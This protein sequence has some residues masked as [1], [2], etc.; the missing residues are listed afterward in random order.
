M[1]RFKNIAC[2]ILVLSV[3]L[4]Y[5]PISSS[6][7]VKPVT[8]RA[9][10]IPFSKGLNLKETF[11]SG[12]ALALEFE[13]VLSPGTVTAEVGGEILFYEDTKTLQVRGTNGHLSSDG[14]I[15]LTGDMVMDF[16]VPLPEAFFEE[17]DNPHIQH[18]GSIP[19]FPR[20]EKGWNESKEFDSF[21][22]SDS[23]PESVKLNVG[24]PQLVSMRL[25]AVEIVPVVT[26]AI[27][28]GGTLTAAVKIFVDHLSDYLDAGIS[29]N[30][31]IASEL[32]L[33][34]KAITINDAPVTHENRLVR[35]PNFDSTEGTYQIESDYDEEF[36]YT[37]D[38]VASSNAYAKVVV[39][40]GIEIWSYDE[41]FAEKR[42]SVIPKST[43]NL[44]F[45]GAA[46]S[47]T[48]DVPVE[49][50]DQWAGPGVI[51][52]PGLASAIRRT[53][54]I[55]QN[56]PITRN[57]MRKLTKL[58]AG[59]ESIRDLTGLKYAVNL[60]ELE[61]PSNAISDVS[62][63]SELKKLENL[64]ISENRL[65]K[66]SLSD[67][68]NLTQLDLYSNPLSEVSLSGM[69]NLT[70][71][72]FSGYVLSEVSLSNMPKLEFLGFRGSTI[73]ELSLSGLTNLTK[74]S[75]SL[76]LSGSTILKLS[77]SGLTNLTELGLASRS[78]SEVSLSDL[79]NLEDLYLS[80]NALSEVSL[81]S[82]PNLINLYLSG[83]ALSEVSL[84][85]MPNLMNLYLE[86]NALSEV[87]L[88][89]MPNLTRLLL[90]DNNLLKIS[91]PDMPNLMYLVLRNNALSEI[92]LPNMPNL[93]FLS[94]GNNTLSEISL[95]DMP[96]LMNLSLGNNALSEI[97]LP[98][99]PNLTNLS[100]PHNTL[101]EISLPSMPNLEVLWLFNNA[102]SEISLSDMPN[103]T[104]LNIQRNPLSK[105]SLSNMPKLEYFSASANPTLEVSL[106]NLPNLQYLDLSG[107]SISEVFLMDLTNLKTLSLSGNNISDVSGLSGLPNLMTLYLDQNNISDV[108]PLIELPNLTDLSLVRNPLNYVS[109]RTHIPA[110][111]ARGV[112][113]QFDKRVSPIFVKIS[114]EDQIGAPGLALPTPFI[115]QVLDVEDKPIPNIPIRFAV[116]QG[117]GT[118]STTN[119]TT[120]ATG[121]A[122]TVLTL[123]P[124]P[125]EN[126]VGVI[127]EGFEEAVSFTATATHEAVTP[128][129]TAED[130]NGDG[131]VNIQDLV[132][133]SSNL[134]QTGENDAD[135]NGDG[136]VNVRD[137]VQI[138]AALQ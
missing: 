78:L 4:S 95:P 55:W 135:I 44:N 137:L 130:V 36:T 69:L 120:D 53:L 59:Y 48:I 34:G 50:S 6:E 118:L 20:I 33:T 17:D 47:A 102:F 87:S 43:F 81:P 90:S 40:G 83:N 76:E 12:G 126:K 42:I 9:E 24:I 101:S 18:R 73:S 3:F 105:I 80:G 136:I 138:A 70:R 98:S 49:P 107:K 11:P 35:P 8:Y 68:P 82:M 26:S 112:F 51:R 27:L 54:D 123:G 88:P 127:A 124:D 77:V 79:P 45:G 39:L 60:I 115:V 97:S 85:S 25:S 52:D 111:Q 19:G 108:S 119:T 66:V 71:L 14:G 86:N 133:V 15:I 23:R 7:E 46:T 16:I 5:T 31:G 91:L 37:L 99:M 10:F 131:V 74:L 109:R 94:L 32:T 56:D 116:Y 104:R 2:V 30:G 64:D 62:P 38:F 67:M 121:K 28:S 96:N 13:L 103:L 125:G 113:V 93:T 89:S 114:G 100:L 134:G 58:W 75:T 117:K 29:L 57:D 106:S 1:T 128:L 22:L 92:S 84:P 122:Q 65:S 72:N 21:L 61:L 63:L 132:L 41:P 129:R 110:M